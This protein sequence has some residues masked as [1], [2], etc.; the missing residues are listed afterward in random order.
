[1]KISEIRDRLDEI[2]DEF[3]DAEGLMIPD[4]E[5]T[6]RNPITDVD[7][8]PERQAVTFAYKD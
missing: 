3:G 6:W 1:M 2:I 5:P 8:E 4:L 7:F